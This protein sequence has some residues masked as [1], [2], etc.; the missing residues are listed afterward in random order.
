VIETFKS[1]HRVP[2]I[3]ARFTARVGL[4]RIQHVERL[5]TWRARSVT[6]QWGSWAEPPT[7]PWVETLVHGGSGGKAPS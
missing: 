6:Q 3:A 1:V 5:R 4:Q 2:I 7:G